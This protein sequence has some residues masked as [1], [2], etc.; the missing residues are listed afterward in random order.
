MSLRNEK[1]AE[2]DKIPAELLN[3]VGAKTKGS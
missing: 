1:A 3:A 2:K